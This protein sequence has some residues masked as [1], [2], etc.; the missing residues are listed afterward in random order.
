MKP[1]RTAALALCLAAPAAAGVDEAIDRHVL[2]GLAAFAAATETLAQNAEAD[3]RPEALQPAF[4]AAFDA[5]MRVADLRLGPSE[6]GALSIAFWPDARGFTPRTLSGLIAD[7]DPVARDAAAYAEVSIA[8]RGLFALEMLLYDEAF[9]GYDAESYTCALVTTVAR[10]LDGQADALVT[11]WAQDYADTLRSA[12]EPG[13]ATFLTEDEAIR[14]LYTQIL[15]GLQF[16]ADQRLG[17]PMGTLDRP[18][19]A[20]A[21]ARRSARSLRNVVLAAEAAH[22]LA[23]ALA[24]GLTDGDLPQTAAAMERVRAA[25]QAVDDPAFQD[26]TDPQARLHAEVLQ[27]AVR[28]L[29]DAIGAELGAPLGIAPGFNSQDGD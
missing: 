21:E 22:D 11:V 19:P 12:G 5:W 9:A 3:C 14:A 7:Q 29:R 1:F 27:Q 24:E 10:D 20:R 26:V 15:S 6:T 25:A 23:A 13:N 28:G 4:Q 16:T 8:A 17:A 2:P 18:R